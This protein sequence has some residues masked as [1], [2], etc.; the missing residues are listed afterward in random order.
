MDKQRIIHLITE[1]VRLIQLGPTHSTFE[2]RYAALVEAKWVV[3]WL[4]QED[5]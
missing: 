3:A 2:E 1:L 4:Q 5:A